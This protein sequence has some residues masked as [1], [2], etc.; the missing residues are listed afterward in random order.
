[1]KLIRKT[2]DSSSLPGSV[3]RVY[4][5]K[6]LAK[7]TGKTSGMK[8]HYFDHKRWRL[9]LRFSIDPGLAWVESIIK[10]TDIVLRQPKEFTENT[11]PSRMPDRGE[12]YTSSFL[13]ASVSLPGS[14]PC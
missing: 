9:D 13:Y 8:Q 1:M 5:G 10:A 14:I 2:V 4:S 3:L 12:F 11:E 7:I 6:I